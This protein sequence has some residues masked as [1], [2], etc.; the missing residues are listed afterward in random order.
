LTMPHALGRL[1]DAAACLGVI[2]EDAEAVL[3]LVDTFAPEGDAAARN[4]I[5]DY[6]LVED[7]P[8]I[9]A[10][11]LRAKEPDDA[12]AA[13]SLNDIPA[14]MQ[15][16]STL[17]DVST[18][19]VEVG[20][21]DVFMQPSNLV[22]LPAVL[23]I[24]LTKA[25]RHYQ[26]IM[27]YEEQISDHLDSH[28]RL[29]WRAI[30]LVF[31]NFPGLD[32]SIR[33]ADG[34]VGD[35]VFVNTIGSG[36]CGQ[37]Y[38]SLNEVTKK[39]EAVK[40]I[41]KKDITEM[42]Q[43]AAVWRECRALRKLQ[44]A[45]VV[46]LNQLIHAPHHLYL[47]MEIAGPQNLVQRIRESPE[48]CLEGPAAQTIFRHIASAVSYCHDK[49]FAHR[50]IKPEN[51]AVDVQDHATLLDFGF[52]VEFKA[53]P[54]GYDDHCGTMPFVAPEVLLGQRY[55]PDAADVWSMGVVLLEM[56]RGMNALMKM[57]GWRSYECSSRYGEE[58]TR[59][60]SS[61][62]ALAAAL[63]KCP[64]AAIPEDALSLLTT[65][66]VPRPSERA[67]ASDIYGATEPKA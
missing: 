43:A 13:A 20:A 1:G 52:A 65:M 59:F 66:L 58:L 39:Q 16:T 14:A 11:L 56:L 42:K 10:M 37:V 55:Q 47:C 35:R 54:D 27:S 57:L 6:T 3:V 22:D 49:G 26:Q 25:K 18:G 45:S 12:D 32:M 63:Q 7:A 33:E 67:R 28:N 23:G 46:R 38:T 8:P 19:L 64:G 50:D 31:N 9:I 61:P 51:I 4:I 40:V 21:D 2:P 24:A 30:H 15:R 62:S 41:S 5:R 60:F 17:V 44:H 34:R 29:F 48:H 36:A 53:K